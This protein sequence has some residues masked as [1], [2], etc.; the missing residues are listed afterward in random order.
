MATY[1]AFCQS[2]DGRG[3]IWIESIEADTVEAAIQIARERCAECWEYSVEDVHCLGIA[4]GDVA[5]EHW[6]DIDA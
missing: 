4:A 6:E 2:T 5:I 3:T 1:T